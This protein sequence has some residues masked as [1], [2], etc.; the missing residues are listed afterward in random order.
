VYWAGEVLTLQ[1]ANCIIIAEEL[2][3]HDGL[4]NKSTGFSCQKLISGTLR[5]YHW[6]FQDFTTR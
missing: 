2:L 1:K 3:N 6:E 5:L 4:F